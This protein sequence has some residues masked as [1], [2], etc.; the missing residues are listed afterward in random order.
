MKANDNQSLIA[1][2][3]VA[4]QQWA[5]AE[6]IRWTLL[7]NYLMAG[8]IL[9]L[10]WATVYTSQ[11]TDN[12]GII[13]ITLSC[14]GILIS[15]LWLAL[16]I[17]ATGFAKVYGTT[18]LNI[19][20]QLVSSQINEAPFQSSQNHRSRIKH[21]PRLVPSH[22]VL[23]SVPVLFIFIFLILLVTS[24]KVQCILIDTQSLLMILGVPFIALVFYS[25]YSLKKNINP[26]ESS[27]TNFCIKCGNRTKE[28][29]AEGR[30]RQICMNCGNIHY[31]Q[32]IVGAG[33]F[34]ERNGEL[35]LI[36]R[37]MEPFLGTWCLPGGHV[38]D[39]EDPKDAAKRETLEETGL[40]IT[41]TK[42]A[43]VFFFNDHPKGS[44]IFLV[45]STN[46]PLGEAIST[47]EG[48][49]PSYFSRAEIPNLS[50]SGG[51]HR[52]AIDAWISQTTY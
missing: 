25:I 28:Q 38:E 23:W 1:L 40:D 46:G 42:P 27:S 35:L 9:V 18:G 16:G 43:N 45:Y 33:T 44:G 21:L 29:L 36:K 15:F 20:R 19:E 26:D 39:N 30:L 22:Y 50:I 4:S 3:Q 41:L 2:Y 14:S 49:N 8:T 13:L 17:R 12:K 6:Q 47:A 5:H 7:Y 52:Q 51:G 10:A 34:V 11:I 31:K 37:K 24:L 48:E 32:L